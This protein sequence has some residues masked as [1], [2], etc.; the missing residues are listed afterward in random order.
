MRYWVIGGVAA[1]LMVGGVGTFSALAGVFAPDAPS[2]AVVAATDPATEPPMPVPDVAA[3]PA[4]TPEFGPEPEPEPGVEAS[5]AS[6]A[7]QA[8]LDY[9]LTHWQDYN[10]DYGVITGNDCVNF[11]SQALVERGWEMDDEWWS[12]GDAN[13]FDYSSPWVSSTA[14]RNYLAGSGRAS[15]LTDDEREQVKIG[16]VVQF[17]WDNSGDRDHTAV[18]SKIVTEGDSIEIFYVGHTD[19]TDYRSVDWAI[20]VNHPGATAY[21]WSIP[22]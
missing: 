4:P 21:Y 22:A 6:E 7:I 14:F 3:P 20:T 16:D 19:D 2:P 5:P 12:A 10:D 8:Q 13:H 9:M 11:T 18:V 1:L 17:D 15:A